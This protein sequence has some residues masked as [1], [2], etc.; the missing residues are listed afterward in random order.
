MDVW[1]RE[2]VS[3]TV[4]ENAAIF[5]RR[6]EDYDRWLSENERA[7]ASELE[8]VRAFIPEVVPGSRSGALKPEGS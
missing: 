1:D 7:Y 8:A 3:Q 4:S 6:T 2:R 5:D